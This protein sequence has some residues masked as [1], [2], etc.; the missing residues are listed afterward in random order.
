MA[1]GERTERRY[2]TCGED[3]DILGTV[4]AE[5]AREAVVS[6]RKKKNLQAAMVIGLYEISQKLDS[7]SDG[8][9]GGFERLGFKIDG[10]GAKIDVVGGDVRETCRK[11]KENYKLTGET[12]TRVAELFGK[13]DGLYPKLDT[14]AELLREMRDS[15]KGQEVLLKEISSKLN[16]RKKR[17]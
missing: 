3:M 5:A 15:H 8:L 9:D 12:N 17:K 4:L 10:L 2:E 14:V 11:V 16:G 6:Y 7:L 1:C 13:F